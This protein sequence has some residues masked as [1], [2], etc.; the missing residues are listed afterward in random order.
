M[1]TVLKYYVIVCLILFVIVEIFTISIY[2]TY[3]DKLK[4][5]GKV[6]MNFLK[7]LFNMITTLIKCF[8]PI[9]NI[10]IFIGVVF[11]NSKVEQNVH[12]I[13]K[14]AREESSK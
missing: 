12:E 2:S 8:I 11:M 6:K 3:K 14:N 9:Y 5:C 7:L 13:V 4:K 1:I 10:F